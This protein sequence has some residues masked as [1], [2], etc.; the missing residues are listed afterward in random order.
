VSLAVTTSVMTARA[1]PAPFA[2]KS[3][4]SNTLSKTPN[5]SLISKSV[6]ANSVMSAAPSRE[7]GQRCVAE[8]VAKHRH[9]QQS[10]CDVPRLHGVMMVDCIRVGRA[11]AMVVAGRQAPKARH[12]PSGIPECLEVEGARGVV[13]PLTLTV[14]PAQA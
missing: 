11:G 2:T 14:S 8:S 6:T 10:Q 3:H 9:A 12:A 13:H 5:P 7:R 4:W 1:R